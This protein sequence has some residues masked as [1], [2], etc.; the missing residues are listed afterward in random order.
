[1]TFNEIVEKDKKFVFPNY[2]R[3]NIALAKGQGAYAYSPDGK[4][5]L[6]FLGGI[7]VCNFGHCNPTINQAVKEQLDTLIHTSN[8]YYTENQAKLAEWISNTSFPGRTFFN[9]SGAEAN[10]TALK[11][12]RFRGNQI[13]EGK[14]VI[15]SLQGS[16]HGR[17]SGSLALTGQAKHQQGFEPLLPNIFHVDFNNIE[18]LK[19]QFNENVAGIIL[20][21]VQ[22]ESGI[23]PVSEDFM[24]A[25]RKL[26]DQYDALMICDEVQTGLG[27]TG[28]Y[29][30]YEHFS[31]IPDGFTLAKSL[32]NG[33]PIGAFHIK[34]EYKEFLPP[35]KHASTFGGN[36]LAT[37]AG[38]EVM[39]LLT[40]GL[41]DQVN[42]VSQL[43]FD[44]LR[45][46]QE[47]YSCI[48]ELRG[49]GLM[50]G[51]E[52][53][54]NAK[55]VLNKCHE[56]GLLCNAIGESVLRFLPPLIITQKEVS[57]FEEKI[58]RVFTQF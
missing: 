44:I 53:F 18:D 32:A 19:Q 26:C 34:E 22:G 58:N 45:S 20:E 17:S 4:E 11:L 51:V 35:G 52:L 2:G 41:L 57:L 9:N 28:K 29:F 8:L 37:R 10:E 6:D 42:E 21:P 48:K 43:L 1:M 13:K 3:Y 40:G 31:V 23:Y 50:I 54:V 30:G 16:F 55:E 36:P 56:E 5:Y 25:V 47:K 49:K 46:C 39:K 12:M 33:I 7:S 27:R 38:I 24:V 15:L 14:N